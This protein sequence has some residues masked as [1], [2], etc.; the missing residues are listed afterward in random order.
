MN[1]SHKY[2]ESERCVVYKECD[3]STQLSMIFNKDTKTVDI[4]LCIFIRNDETMLEP[5]DAE[6]D[7]ISHSAK[8]GH[9]QQIFP[10]LGVGDIEFLYKKTREL[11]GGKE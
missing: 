10:T 1:E 2:N 7:W 5:M 9:W 4:S 11:F 8:Y 3:D 6:S